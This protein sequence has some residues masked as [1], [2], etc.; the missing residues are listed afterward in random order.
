MKLEQVLQFGIAPND[1]NITYAGA[2][3][4]A[5]FLSN[6]DELKVGTLAVMVQQGAPGEWKKY[7]IAE[8]E[9][10]IPET[11]VLEFYLWLGGVPDNDLAKWHNVRAIEKMLTQNPRIEVGL[12]FFLSQFSAG[13][14]MMGTSFATNAVTAAVVKAWTDVHGLPDAP[15]VEPPVGDP[16][17]ITPTGVVGDW[18]FVHGRANLGPG[19]A[20]Y[21][22][23]S[24][25]TEPR[26]TFVR[27]AE[28]WQL[29]E[30]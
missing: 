21:L 4:I 29:K 2:K 8:I 13:L 12:N 18:S 19:S 7:T 23:G 28:W 9:G 24:E 3:A 14:Y 1:A 10:V 27:M 20:A 6:I 5:A 11:A 25:V 30:N 17:V 16:P 22:I 26:G 15:P